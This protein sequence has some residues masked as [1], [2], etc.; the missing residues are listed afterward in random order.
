LALPGIDA[1][2]LSKTLHTLN[3]IQSVAYC[4]P[5]VDL[6]KDH[7]EIHDSSLAIQWVQG[8]MERME[9]EGPNV[10]ID[11]RTELSD[12]DEANIV[13]SSTAGFGEFVLS[14][15]GKVFTLLENLPE[16]SR[17]RSGSP[18]E[19]VINTLPAALTPL[20]ASLSPEIF[21]SALEKVAAFVSGH[22]VHQA[23][24]A[25]AFICNSLCK[26]NPEKTLKIFVPML[27]VGIRNEID[28]NEAASDRS[29]GSDVL[30][31][32]RA[33]V[34]HIS[35]LSMIIVH[36]GDSLMPYKKELFDIALYMQEKCRGI[37]TIH[38]SNYIHHLLLNLTL[39]YPVDGALYEPDVLKRGLDVG[40]WGKTIK[41]TELTIN[42]HKPSTEEIEFAVELF[43]SQ[44]KTATE[45]LGN[46][47]SDNPTVSRKGK[48]KEWSDEVSRNLSQLRLI[49]SGIA[50]LFDPKKA[51]GQTDKGEDTDGDIIMNGDDASDE[52][53]KVHWR[54]QRKTRKPDLSS[55]I[56][57]A[58]FSRRIVQPTNI[59]IIYEKMSVS[60]CRRFTIFSVHIRKMTWRAS[61]LSTKHTARGSRMLATK[62]L[63]TCL[64]VSVS[65]TMLI[66]EPSRLVDCARSIQD[67]FWSS[68]RQY[69]TSSGQNTIH[70]PDTSLS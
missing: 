60:S 18:E 22:V 15:L 10:E 68:E 41:P 27:I 36:V 39:I 19:S 56:V 37:P 2:D 57:Q 24:D 54:K 23:R 33:L 51:S 64:S 48:N 35:M 12:E 58:I 38:I 9:R 59:S 3:F 55:T 66:S 21:D 49:I 44:V 4:V 67:P 30:P 7:H 5:F 1:N 52:M 47:I 14:L 50:T 32:D 61:R 42:W 65:S 20:F 11:Y 13:R 45:R 40:D 31:R 6:T 63:P 70:R 43:E 26:A 16:L 69:I 62:D 8:E 34:W 29:S 25:M 28:Y 46:L 17:V 53:R